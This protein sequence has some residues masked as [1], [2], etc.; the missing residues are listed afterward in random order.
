MIDISNKEKTLRKA[1][2]SITIKLNQEIAHKI[3]CNQ[4]KKGN[5]LEC[6][7]IAGIMAVKNTSNIIPFCHNIEIE[8]AKFA[9]AFQGE[10]LVITFEI[11]AYAK[12]GVE[13][14]SLTAASTAALTVYDMCKS[15]SKAIEI[16]N[17]FLINKSG[18][19]TGDYERRH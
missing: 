13:M 15:I 18:G 2:A 10:E 7:K 17:L 9:Y 16:T 14:E 19:K 8:S 11:C 1:K 4:I 5:V 12:T 3:K 6:A